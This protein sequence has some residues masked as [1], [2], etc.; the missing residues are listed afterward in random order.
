MNFSLLL[1]DDEP[2][3]LSS[4][5]RVFINDGYEIHTATGGEEALLVIGRNRIDAALI[6]LMMPDMDGHTLLGRIK[7]LDPRIM[8]VMLTGYGGIQEAVTAIKAGAEDFLQKPFSNEILL[9]SIGRLRRIWLLEA[10]NRR[11]NEEAPLQF[12]YQPLVGNSTAMLRLK[13]TIAKVALS[14]TSVLIQG[15]TGTGK[16]L[17]ARAIHHHSLRANNDFVPVDCAAISP[18]MMESEMF[19]HVKG[20]FTGAYAAT[21]GLIRAADQGT[22][23][24]DE[25]GELPLAIQAKLLRTLQEREVRP[26]GS[27]KTQT[28]EVRILAATNRSL[29]AEVEKGNFRQDLLF[30]LNVV[31]LPL[32]SLRDRKED[33]PLLAR[34]LVKRFGKGGSPVKEISPE[35]MRCLDQYHWPG[36]VRELENVIRRAVALG[37]GEAILPADLPSHL[38]GTAES[39]QANAELLKV[40]SLAAYE[41]SAILDA[42]QK[43]K[44]NRKKTA[45]ILGIGEATLYRK[46]KKYNL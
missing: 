30:R 20:A 24:L 4:L 5:K 19:G 35:A 10:E 43:S 38:L 8:V 1:V 18:T 14:D 26:V 28:V 16:E 12:D 9:A 6:D 37:S 45:E 34:Y 42:L 11:L 3:I 15:E 25:I 40:G 36:N 39:Q 32:P 17:V 21:P 13:Q 2:S 31:T 41:R 46:L 22:L 23:F 27:H 44:L 33:I 29:S 7:K